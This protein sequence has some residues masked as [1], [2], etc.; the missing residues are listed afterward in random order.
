MIQNS[1]I[2][3]KVE[4][5]IIR[6]K[7]TDNTMVSGHINLNR[8]ADGEYDRLSDLLTKNPDQFLV[9]YSATETSC[10]LDKNIKHKVI[11]VNRQY[12]LW[13]I[14]EEDQM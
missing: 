5:R 2:C 12:I 6:I 14:P 13:A 8:N 3:K 11:F 9:V 10:G 1:E 7:L 4:S